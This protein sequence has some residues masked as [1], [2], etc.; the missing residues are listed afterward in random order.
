M[1]YGYTTYLEDNHYSQETVN[2]Y[3]K[4]INLF[5]QFIDDLYGKQKE[6]FQIS[7]KDIKDYLERLKDDGSSINT[8]NKHLSILKGFFDYLWEND[9]IPVDPAMKIKRHKVVEEEKEFDISYEMLLQI[10]PQVLSNPKYSLLRKVIFI[11]AMKGL[12]HTEFQILKDNIEDLGEEVLIKF[13]KYSLKLAGEEG[14][15]FLSYYFESNF[16]GS[17]YVFTTKKHDESIVPIEHMS[18]YTHLN[19]ITDEFKLPSKITLNGIRHSYAYYLYINKK[20][21]IQKIAETL[22]IENVSASHLVKISMNRHK[23]KIS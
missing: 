19:A 8:V 12:R 21:P 3:K 10:L 6:I 14:E 22:R 18:I 1:P 4:I 9:K 20:Y 17:D 11:L 5:F 13:K 16:N 15:Y 2:D 7:P 23:Q